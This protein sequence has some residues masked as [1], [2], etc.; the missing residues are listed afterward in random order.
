MNVQV[1]HFF[2]G[3]AVFYRWSATG[4]SGQAECDN[5]VG[6]AAGTVRIRTADMAAARPSSFRL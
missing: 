2:E 4:R 3:G 1:D 5:V 6:A